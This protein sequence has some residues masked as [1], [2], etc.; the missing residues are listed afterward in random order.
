MV[1]VMQ[2]LS[3]TAPGRVTIDIDT[4]SVKIE[5][6]YVT[7]SHYFDLAGALAIGAFDVE[8]AITIDGSSHDGDVTLRRSDDPLAPGHV[9]YGDGPDAWVDR[10]L[11]SWIRA[12]TGADFGAVLSAL[13]GAARDAIAWSEIDCAYDDALALMGREET[14]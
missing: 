3:I 7:F 8:V 5:A 14:P 11:L 4:G 10:A 9:A 6:D 13:E 1:R 2:P 12:Y